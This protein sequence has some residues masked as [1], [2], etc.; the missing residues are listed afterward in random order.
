M[1]FDIASEEVRHLNISKYFDLAR[2]PSSHADP[3]GTLVV[4]GGIN[5]SIDRLE[6]KALMVDCS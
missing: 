3:N 4:S 6:S 5:K 2:D 1:Q